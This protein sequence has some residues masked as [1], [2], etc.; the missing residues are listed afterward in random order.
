MVEMPYSLQKCFA[1]YVH[2]FVFPKVFF[3]SYIV[4]KFAHN[5]QAYSSSMLA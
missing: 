1:F 4:Y 2:V 3:A 5:A